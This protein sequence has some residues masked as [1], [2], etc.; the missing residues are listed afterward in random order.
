MKHGWCVYGAQSAIYSS[1]INMALQREQK[2]IVLTLETHENEAVRWG[3]EFTERNPGF[4]NEAPSAW[5]DRQASQAEAQARPPSG[6][7]WLAR[8]DLSQLGH[9]CGFTT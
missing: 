5:D 4:A 9:D 6:G 2:T 8:F 1:R 3:G 7:V